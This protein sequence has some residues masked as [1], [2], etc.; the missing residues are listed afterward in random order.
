MVNIA[1]YGKGGIG[2]STIISNVTA[3][4]AEKG[5][6]VLQIGC[7]PKHDSTRLLLGGF[8]QSTVLEQLNRSDSVSLGEVMLTGYKGAKCIESGGP[9][10]GVG[11]AGRGNTGF[12]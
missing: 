3:A 9:E 5:H 2:K 11:C 4:L 8:Q 10:P 12:H 7:D 6:K 1:F